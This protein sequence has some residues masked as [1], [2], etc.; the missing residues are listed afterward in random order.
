MYFLWGSE[1]SGF[2]QIYLYEVKANA[3]GSEGES[4]GVGVGVGVWENKECCQCLLEGQA[5]GGGGH[6]VV[7]TI[8]CVD[9]NRNLV[10]FSGTHS[11]SLNT[12]F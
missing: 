5:I 4:V 6:W 7:E 3:G 10:Y 11:Q 12:L 2:M 8:D 1:R 9:E